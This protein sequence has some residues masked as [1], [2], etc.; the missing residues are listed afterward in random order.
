MIF[1]NSQCISLIEPQNY[2][3][4]MKPPNVSFCFAW[5]CLLSC[6]YKN[7]NNQSGI[8]LSFPTSVLYRA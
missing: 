1:F 3:F 4:S 8:R 5:F 6:Q 2:C 7:P